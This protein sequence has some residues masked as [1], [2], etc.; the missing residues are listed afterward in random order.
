MHYFCESRELVQGSYMLPFWEG[1]RSK[2]LGP[3]PGP[4]THPYGDVD[5]VIGM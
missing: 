4:G 5:P 1:E 2:R 3:A